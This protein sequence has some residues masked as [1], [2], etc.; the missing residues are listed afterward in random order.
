[1]ARVAVPFRR[2][3]QSEYVRD[4]QA[5][6][7]VARHTRQHV[8]A[9]VGD[10]GRGVGLAH[11]GQ[12]D[13]D[14]LTRL[15]QQVQERAGQQCRAPVIDRRVT[16][17]QPATGAG[18]DLVEQQHLVGQQVA[19]AGEGEAGLAE[20]LAFRPQTQEND[21]EEPRHCLPCS[22]FPRRGGFRQPSWRHPGPGSERN[23]GALYASGAAAVALKASK[24]AAGGRINVCT[25]CQTEST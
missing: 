22:G 5:G 17:H 25:A 23:L 13:H 20:R 6:Q 10:Q 14:R 7:R 12:A 9:E 1:M 18:D 15:Q 19:D 11:L 3:L 16:E 8:L 4:G 21:H 2:R 24:A